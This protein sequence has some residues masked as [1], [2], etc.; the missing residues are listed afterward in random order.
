M[1]EK[2]EDENK[3]SCCIK[4]IEIMKK[5]VFNSLILI[6]FIMINNSNIIM[7]E[8]LNNYTCIYMIIDVKFINSLTLNIISIDII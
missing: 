4:K 2:G 8:K 5:V 1:Y 3:S 6:L 7:N